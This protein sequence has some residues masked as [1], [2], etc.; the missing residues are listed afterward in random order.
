MRK[1]IKIALP[2]YTAEEEKF[3]GCMTKKDRRAPY[4]GGWQPRSC[5]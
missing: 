5:I 2:I 1:E 3:S 4:A